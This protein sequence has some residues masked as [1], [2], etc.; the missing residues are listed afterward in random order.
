MGEV[1]SVGDLLLAQLH[2]WDEW[3]RGWPTWKEAVRLEPPFKPFPGH[4]LPYPR[5]V[6]ESRPETPLSR[7][8]DWLRGRPRNQALVQAVVDQVDPRREARYVGSDQTLTVLQVVIGKGSRLRE[9]EG[10][11]L[12]MSLRGLRSALSFEIIG[13]ASATYLQIVCRDHDEPALRS[14]VGAYAPQV[15]LRSVEADPFREFLIDHEENVSA[16]AQLGLAREC[17]L[18]LRIP[19]LSPEPLLAV[20][21]ALQD[22]QPAE[23]A[24]IQV[25]F[26]GARAPWAESLIRA[27]KTPDGKDFFTD[28][29][30]IAKLATEKAL[31]PL[32]GVVLRIFVS[33]PQAHAAQARF[34]RLASG[35]SQFEGPD[36]NGFLLVN[37]DTLDDVGWLI[38][39]VFR[40]SRASGMLLS[41]DELLPFVHFPSGDL[42]IP[43]LAR[44]LGKTKAAPLQPREGV[45]VGVNTHAGKAVE[46][47]LDAER[48]ARHLHLIGASG[49]GKTN[50]LLQLLSGLIDQGEG[51]G[52]LDP[53]GDLVDDLLARI[54]QSRKDDVVLFDPS[55]EEWPIGFNVLQ[56]HTDLERTLLASDL[57][58]IF[59]RLSTSWGDQMHAVF[60]QAVQAVLESDS[61]GTIADL[62]RFLIDS[63]FRREFLTGVRDEETVYYWT[64]QYPL[65][66]GRPEAPILTR[67]DGFLRP[68]LIRNMVGQKDTRLDFRRIVDDGKI[69]LAKLAQGAIGEENAALLG[70][71]LTAKFH[72]VAMS[73]QDIAR[74]KRRGFLLAIDEFQNFLT[75]SMA[76]L[77]SGARKFGLG[78]AL[79]HQ[80]LHQL[81][82]RDADIYHAVMANAGTRIVFRVSDDDAKQLADGFAAFLP[83]DLRTL[84]V[85]DAVA[86]YG[87][88]DNDFSLEVPLASSVGEDEASTRRALVRERSRAQ[89][90]THLTPKPQPAP[91]EARTSAPAPDPPR[92]VPESQPVRKAEK[93]SAPKPPPKPP[94]TLGRGGPQHKY[95]QQLVKELAEAHHY[96]AT[97]EA[98][99]ADGCSIDV[100]LERAGTRIACEI[101]IA[102]GA[103]Q[104]LSNVRKCLAAGFTQI[105]VLATEE[106][107]LGKLAAAITSALTPSEREKVSFLTFEA[108]VARF[109][110]EPAEKAST[111]A[112]Y[113]VRVSY[114]GSAGAESKRRAISELLAKSL[115]RLAD[116]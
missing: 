49:S 112:G 24:G 34:M 101:S 99:L 54:P 81:R 41:L 16:I 87:T 103:E 79:A 69:F 110:A 18:P 30:H 89:Y 32:Y 9:E 53:H 46:V 82:N 88:A 114:G 86:R 6:E 61:G 93:A 90:A 10:A 13:T 28:A 77:L 29:P 68:R 8:G 31:Q 116:K 66:R 74:E 23:L 25:L 26:E 4:V 100:L 36:R 62:R 2:D 47:R 96:R 109:G 78:L 64:K 42:A 19:S 106:K 3:G 111:V 44:E 39:A 22:L 45:L 65:L 38:D 104:E 51:L 52:V 12:L 95:L 71:F 107:K 1:H 48:R 108:L 35:I 91:E 37:E 105:F 73:R 85:G 115:S 58:G 57:V 33:A 14:T 83:E 11:A 60:S 94:A 20:F 67:L 76:S 17:M 5:L 50:L 40:R 84:A 63:D 21:S 113:N 92:S 80:D 43:G 72:Q 55:D 56:A 75:P 15:T 102:S 70:S 98:P 59:R 27:V 97:I 7:L